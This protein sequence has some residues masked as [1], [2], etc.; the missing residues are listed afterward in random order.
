MRMKKTCNREAGYFMTSVC[1]ETVS[2]LESLLS[3]Q[4]TQLCGSFGWLTSSKC[5]FS[6]QIQNHMISPIFFLLSIAMWEDVQ[7][8]APLS[9]PPWGWLHQ[10]SGTSSSGAVMFNPRTLDPASVAHKLCSVLMMDIPAGQLSTRSQ[11]LLLQCHESRRQICWVR[12]I[13]CQMQMCSRAEP[14]AAT[15]PATTKC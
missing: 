6:S 9:L 12:G 8:L 11:L 7:H 10:T 4:V 5:V 2:F 15:L 1:P 3:C 14:Q 13:P